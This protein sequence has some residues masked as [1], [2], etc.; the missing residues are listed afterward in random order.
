MKKKKIH[1]ELVSSKETFL[2]E[3]DFKERRKHVC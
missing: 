1:Q 2:E 3:R